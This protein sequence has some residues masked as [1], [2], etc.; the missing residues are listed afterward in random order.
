MNI[1]RSVTRRGFNVG[2]AGWFTVLRPNAWFPASRIPSFNPAGRFRVAVVPEQA[3][4]RSAQGIT[5]PPQIVGLIP[6]D[7]NSARIVLA[8]AAAIVITSA[9]LYWICVP[10]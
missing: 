10:R 5:T 2:T 1:L 7:R 9:M 8:T 6:S 3:A 4:L